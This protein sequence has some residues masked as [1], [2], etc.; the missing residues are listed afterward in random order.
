MGNN[1][2]R[3]AYEAG[4]ASRAVQANDA[5]ITK[6]HRTIICRYCRAQLEIKVNTKQ[7]GRVSVVFSCPR[8]GVLKPGE[9]YGQA[10]VSV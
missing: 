3:I 6:V 5:R 9:Q 2:R 7:S 4:K 8:H 10:F 1:F